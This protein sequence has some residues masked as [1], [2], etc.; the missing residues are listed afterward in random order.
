[1]PAALAVCFACGVAGA[2]DAKDTTQPVPP[3]KV[4]VIAPAAPVAPVIP[5]VQSIKFRE[6]P[7]YVTDPQ[8][9]R[10]TPTID[11]V[12]ADG[13][14]DPFYTIDDAPIKGTVYCNWDDRFLYLAARTDSPATVLFDVDAGG[15]GWLRGSD[16]I[17]VVVGPA[18]PSGGAPTV[19]VRLLDASSTKDTPIWNETGV[20]PKTLVVA[21][22]TN[23][24]STGA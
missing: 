24:N 8:R 18:P 16:N 21:E 23:G 4:D 5:A 17:E 9:L 14:W 1:M 6:R 10:R 7:R 13:E 20:D 22:K 11:G 3:A 15:D 2:Q 12:I 19:S